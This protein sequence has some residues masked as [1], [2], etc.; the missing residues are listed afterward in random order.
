M[1]NFRSE[2]RYAQTTSK[3][4]QSLKNPELVLPSATFLN[5]WASR[6]P[7]NPGARTLTHERFID[8]LPVRPKCLRDCETKVPPSSNDHY[9]RDSCANVQ[10]DDHPAVSSL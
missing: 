3:I 2:K 5:F 7:W 1:I 8:A 6:K 4:P 10:T 9:K